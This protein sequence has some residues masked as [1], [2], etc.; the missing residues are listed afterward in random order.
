M[1]PPRLASRFSFPTA[2]ETAQS[3]LVSL[4]S[5]RFHLTLS[6]VRMRAGLHLAVTDAPLRPYKLARHQG[7]IRPSFCG[8]HEC[9]ISR[10]DPP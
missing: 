8:G 4:L 5:N 10:V 3:V 6:S 2:I 1:V 7:M 9:R